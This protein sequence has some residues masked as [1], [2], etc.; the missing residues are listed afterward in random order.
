[1]GT[2]RIEEDSVIGEIDVTDQPEDQSTQCLAAVRVLDSSQKFDFAIPPDQSVESTLIDLVIGAQGTR[3]LGDRFPLPASASFF[4]AL[5]RVRKARISRF[6]LGFHDEPDQL[7]SQEKRPS[8]RSRALAA[9][10]WVFVDPCT[11]RGKGAQTDL[12]AR[13]LRNRRMFSGILGALP[14]T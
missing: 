8:W 3:P 10:R 6:R 1:M 14:V 11:S 4:G 9:T 7:L 2:V 13:S 12:P 5:L